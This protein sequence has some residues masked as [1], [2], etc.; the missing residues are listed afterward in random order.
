MEYKV[1]S[2]GSDGKLGVTFGCDLIKIKNLLVYS[3]HRINRV[4]QVNTNNQEIEII[5]F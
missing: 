4:F 2:K 5:N 1:L 3:K